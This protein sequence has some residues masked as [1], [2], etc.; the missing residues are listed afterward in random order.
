M[1]IG[2]V[3]C[4]AMGS[5]YAG[6]LADAGNDVI[7][8][9]T[10]REHIEKINVDGLRVE[11]A[12]GDRTVNIQ[13]LFEP[14]GDPVDL[15]IIA[16]KSAQAA[17]AAASSA[18][19]LSENTIVL[20]IQNGL[21]AADL[22]ADAVGEERLIVG[23]AAAFGASLKGPGHAH[24]NGMEAIKLGPFNSLNN[25]IVDQVAKVWLDAGFHAEA[26]DNVIA[27]QWDKL[28][29]NVA[30][31]A[32]CALT[33]LTV[34]EVMESEEVGPVS[35]TA[36][37]EA[38]TVARARGIAISVDDPIGHIQA[39]GRRVFNAKPSVLLDHEAGR[40]SEIDYINGAIPRE[41]MKSDLTAPVN[42]TLVN[43]IKHKETMLSKSKC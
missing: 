8:V 3:G 11:G 16:V 22:V 14:K 34:G 35:R 1:R 31:S 13:A 18:P 36:A 17:T 29:C 40:K 25:E 9:D 32:P 38:W 6:L 12:S 37:T 28:I 24:H 21:G 27:M 33:N 23:I 15:L 39:F 30:Y 42:E 4:G 10:W 5:V 20:T 26:V 43:L 41:A 2:I 7:V 19:F